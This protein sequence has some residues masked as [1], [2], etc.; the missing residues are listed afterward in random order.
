M[1]TRSLWLRWTVRDLR[2]RWP[3]VFAIALVIALGTG[4]YAGLLSTGAWRT[5]S[6]DASF[7]RLHVHDLRVALGEGATVPEGTLAR[8]ARGLPH[9]AA[10]TG[11][12]ERLVVPTQVD[13]GHGVLVAGQV[14]GSAGGDGAA[15]DTVSRSAGRALTPQDDGRAT[16]VLERQFAT[17]NHLSDVGRLRL[18]GGTPTRYVGLGQSPEYFIVSGQQD[19]MPFLSQKSFAV[20]FTSLHSAQQLTASPARVNDLVLT[21]RSSAVA[22]VRADLRRVLS[23]DRSVPSASVTGRDDIDAYRVL[24]DDIQ[25]DEQLWRVI[26]LLV[27]AGAAFATFNLTSRVVEAQRRE[28]GVGMALG[29]PPRTLA[30]RP[31]L[32]GAE[33]A[34][35]GVAAGVGVGALI[36]VPLRAMFTDVLPL[37]VWRTPFQWG[38]FAQAGAL[39]LVLPLL[40]VG[41]PVWRAVRVE[42]VEAIRVGALSGRGSGLARLARHVPGRGYRRMPVRSV[43][44]TPRRTLLTTLGVAAVIATLV[45][46]LGFLDSFRATLD[47][48]EDDLLRAA[49]DRVTVSLRSPEAVDGPAVKAV[50]ALPQVARAEPGLRVAAV[51]RSGGRSVPVLAE[52]LGPAAPWRPEIVAGT[53]TGGIVLARKAASDLHVH[54]AGTVEL[55]HPRLTPEGL[56]T[57]VSPV[58]VAGITPNPM[59]AF[60]YLDL[61]TAR[62]LGLTGAA[63]LLTV[64][65]AAHASA[66]AVQRALLGVAQVAAAQSVRTTTADMRDSL[67]QFVGILTVTAAVTLLLALLIAFNTSSIG[68]DERAREHAT[69]L[70]FGLPTR[71]VLGLAVVES[72]IL[73]VLAT[74]VG[75]VGGY[76]LLV[77][78]T[79]T[80]VAQVLPEIGVEASL[81]AGTPAIAFGLGVLTVGAA[82][83][84]HARAMRRLDIPA[85]L[86][87]V[88]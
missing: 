70:A 60:A 35:I 88:E 29:V 74:V 27:L 40:A 52:T 68:M 22:A 41:W 21:V 7:G 58:R 33:I 84:L 1:R 30:I 24:Y 18:S 67:R 80:T 75:V 46:M 48:S 44:R 86:R 54:V 12:R 63:N 64:I 4:T 87:V 69:M 55:E 34:L 49:P 66:S 53:A 13:A 45:T 19:A 78:L 6:N 9:A 83:L 17:Q 62:R 2:R 57:V 8:L 25:G 71:A 36:G 15:V 56:R 20:L 59:R 65:P 37:P 28:I 26:A 77:W 61:R 81:A 31:L 76:L 51:A 10:L 5:Q 50:R 23:A 32:F 85:T 38:T 47:T 72:A 16:V 73:G 11:V 3:Q 43:L 39:G 82:P 14:V 79:S 42:P